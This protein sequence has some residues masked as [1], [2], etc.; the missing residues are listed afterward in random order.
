MSSLNRNNMSSDSDFVRLESSDGYT[1]VVTRAVARQS[2]MLKS[3]L[4]PESKSMSFTLM[5]ES[6]EVGAFG[7][8]KSG[9]CK[10]HQR[11]VYSTHHRSRVMLNVA[12]GSYS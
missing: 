5:N 6:D 7:E 10:I 1:F 8:A 3:M 9:V 4:D 2:G 12:E 11:Y